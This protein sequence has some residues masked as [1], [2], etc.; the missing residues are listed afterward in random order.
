VTAYRFIEQEKANHSIRLMCRVLRV[1]RSGFYDW[2]GREDCPSADLPLRTRIRAIH[3]E[4]RGTYG[5]PRVNRQLRRQG[6][7]VNRKRVVRLMRQ[8]GLAGV[9]KRRF[10]VQTTQADPAARKAANL[11]NRQFTADAPDTTWVADITYLRTVQGWSYLAVVIDL[12]SRKIVGWA[13]ENQ[14]EASL[15]I[16]AL[17][18][19]LAVRQPR[20]GLLHHSDR[21]SQ[22]TSL[23][24][25]AL[26]DEHQAV[27]SMSRRG[28]CWDNAVAESFFGTFKQEMQSRQPFRSVA[29][30]RAEV[31]NY[32]HQFY[33]PVR[34]H[35]ANGHR[36]P[37]QT[38]EMFRALNS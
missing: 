1:S 11:L 33:N 25:Q 31:G 30:A 29:H 21:G 16:K 35:S 13:V 26:L 19:A 34:L 36:S 22:Y 12:Y 28:N 6:L 2:S 8:E 3:A 4:S 27:A 24:Y 7:T 23:A 32:I 14:M 18:R 10:R 20:P 9:P 38:E 5:T 17:R 37:V 15:C